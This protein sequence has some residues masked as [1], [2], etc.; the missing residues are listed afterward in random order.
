MSS[1]FVIVRQEHIDVRQQFAPVARGS[2]AY[3][4]HDIE[5]GLDAVPRAGGKDRNQFLLHESRHEQITAE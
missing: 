5:H 4:Q 1:A 3:R 2:P